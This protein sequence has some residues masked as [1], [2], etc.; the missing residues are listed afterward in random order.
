MDRQACVHSSKTSKYIGS[1]FFVGHYEENLAYKKF[2]DEVLVCRLY[3]VRRW[4]SLFGP[5]GAA[6]TPSFSASSELR[7]VNW[8]YQTGCPGKK[9]RQLYGILSAG[10]V[11]LTIDALRS[12]FGMVNGAWTVKILS[13]TNCTFLRRRIAETRIQDHLYRVELKTIFCATLVLW[14]I[15]THKVGCAVLV[16]RC[17][18]TLIQIHLSYQHIPSHTL[19]F[20]IH[21]YPHHLC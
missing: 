13:S 2:S 12:W 10:S 20:C 21:F 4:W 14:C 18:N 5:A 15:H 17:V 1:S 19:Y 7:M 9:T 8:P 6:A 3:G 16:T 11:F